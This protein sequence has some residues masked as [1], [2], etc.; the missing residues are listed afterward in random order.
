[1]IVL[2]T[3]CSSPL[4]T[5]ATST[6][7]QRPA[8][9]NTPR[10]IVYA[11]LDALNYYPELKAYQE[12]CSS[13][14]GCAQLLINNGWVYDALK[15][16]QAYGDNVIPS[17]VRS[18]K[19][20][21]GQCATIAYAI[22][23]GV[24]DDGYPPNILILVASDFS[25]ALYVY[26]DTNGLWGYVQ[27]IELAPNTPLVVDNHAPSFATINNL[28]TYYSTEGLHSAD[29]YKYY[30]MTEKDLP[31]DWLTSSKS[32]YMLTYTQTGP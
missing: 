5:K 20:M 1:M 31:V 29:F 7:T 19:K 17:P 10:P 27:I 28:Y 3:S 24:L 15:E 2:L 16:A 30:F 14:A 21:V 11:T 6:P 18:L 12:G 4:F 26:Q 8:A 23:A 25:H 22:A 13:P 9:T 32:V